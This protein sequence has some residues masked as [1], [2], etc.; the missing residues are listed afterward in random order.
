MPDRADNDPQRN[1][2]SVASNDPTPNGRWAGVGQVVEGQF[3]ARKGSAQRVREAE[4]MA[5]RALEHAGEVG[6][7]NRRLRYVVEELSRQLQ[8]FLDFIECCDEETQRVAGSNILASEAAL[9]Q[10]RKV[11]SDA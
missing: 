10:A 9:E 7:E 3:G 5:R 1:R 8:G 4:L 6:T 2:R 11:A